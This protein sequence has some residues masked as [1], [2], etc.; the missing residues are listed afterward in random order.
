MRPWWSYPVENL[1]PDLDVVS[2]GIA[3]ACSKERH[4]ETY[5]SCLDCRNL[6]HASR[7]IQ[8][9]YTHPKEAKSNKMTG[10]EVI[11]ENSPPS[12]RKGSPLLCGWSWQYQR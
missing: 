11:A 7:E 8:S 5:S 2:G 9:P 12:L 3:G 10:Y 6:P 1:P 4:G